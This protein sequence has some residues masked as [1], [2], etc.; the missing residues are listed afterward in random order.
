[1]GDR[2]ERTERSTD[3]DGQEH[4]LPGHDGHRSVLSFSP[5][6]RAEIVLTAEEAITPSD[7]K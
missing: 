6:E 5:E 3:R 1:V 4:D 2:V 7:D